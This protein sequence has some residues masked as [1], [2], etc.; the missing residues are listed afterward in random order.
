MFK[1]PRFYKRVI[2]YFSIERIWI[3]FTESKDVVK[4][5]NGNF[6]GVLK[7][8]CKE[9][10]NHGFLICC[11]TAKIGFFRIFFMNQTNFHVSPCHYI[12]LI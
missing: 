12:N 3:E 11:N 10:W 7:K 4:K 2:K 6:Y 1:Y 8:D 5:E 9:A